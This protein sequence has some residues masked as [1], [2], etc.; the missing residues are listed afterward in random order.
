MISPAVALAALLTVADGGLDVREIK[1]GDP[2]PVTGCVMDERA[3]VSTAKRI[4]K[5]E[6][7]NEELRNSQLVYEPPWVLVGLAL[8][9][10]AAGGFAGG[11]IVANR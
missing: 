10:G 3:C 1:L 5:A 6:T 7:E 8:L 11:Y 9:L 2:S 4:T